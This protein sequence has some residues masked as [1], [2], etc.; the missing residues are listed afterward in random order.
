MQL[1]TASGSLAGGVLGSIIG[2]LFE[3]ECIAFITGGFLYFSVNGLLGELKKVE[4]LLQLFYC[5][6]SMS[7]GLYFMYVF[8]LY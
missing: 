8:A 5:S 2:E 3:K 6:L 7:F 4:S 1:V